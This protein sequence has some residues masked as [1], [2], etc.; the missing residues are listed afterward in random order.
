[1]AGA[2]GNK[3]GSQISDTENFPPMLVSSSNLVGVLYWSVAKLYGLCMCKHVMLYRTQT[4]R[5]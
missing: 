4:S 2:V 3:H 5:S 1:M